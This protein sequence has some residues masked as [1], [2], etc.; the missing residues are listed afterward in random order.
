MCGY[1]GTT[2]EKLSTPQLNMFLNVSS[3]PCHSTAARGP[4]IAFIF[5]ASDL[6]AAQEH[7]PLTD[8]W[9]GGFQAHECTGFSLG[10]RILRC[11]GDVMNWW[12][13]GVPYCIL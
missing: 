3:E 10:M 11:V 5:A 7:T 6:Q 13:S 1:T 4:I 12:V 2:A 8:L 9:P